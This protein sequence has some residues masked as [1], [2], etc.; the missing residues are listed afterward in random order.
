MKDNKFSRRT[1]I[2]DTSLVAGGMVVGAL[3]PK[4]YAFSRKTEA[5][6]RK[7]P[8]Y[9][10]DME[11]RRLGKTN[12]WV[13]AVCLGGHW[14]RVNVMKQDFTRNR[15]D[16]VS[17]C[18]DVGIN[19]IDACCRSEVLAYSKAL[20]GRRDKMYMAL[21]YCG[22]E[23]RDEKY[24]TAKKLME[25]FD[26]LL[27]EA[28]QDYTDLWRITCNEPGGKHSF[29]TSCELVAA[30][31]KAKKQGKARFIGISSHDRQWHKMMIEYFPQ[32]EVVLFPYTARSKVAPE[33]SLFDA[34]KKHDIGVFGIKPFASNSLFKGSSAPGDPHAQEDDRLARL[35]IRYILC[36]DAITAPIP[37]LISPHQVDNMA[38]AVKERRELDLN[39]RA[40]LERAVDEM[41]AKLPANYQ[42]LKN[43][44][45]V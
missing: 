8:S 3:A 39:E 12:L 1:F 26:S 11:Y 32:I 2:R 36:N 37:G 23:V 4:G 40:E 16:V 31:E 7:T 15:S 19:Y 24:R 25:S 21:S 28:K 10:P 18:I 20:A 17:R 45:Y 13:S 38:K 30:L 14:K 33:D 41:W 27:A 29:N 9:N 43:W 34:A 35:A 22:R 42:W 44:E 5:A 6:I